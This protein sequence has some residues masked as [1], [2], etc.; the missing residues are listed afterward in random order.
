MHP[1]FTYRQL[2]AAATPGVLDQARLLAGEVTGLDWDEHSV[3]GELGRYG[4]GELMLHHAERPLTGDCPCRRRKSGLC[5]HLTAVALACLG[6]DDEL[7]QALSRLP[8][9]DLVALLCDLADRS[10]QAR[11]AIRARTTS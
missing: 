8:H 5:V 1:D 2:R 10:E 3:W 7:K 11:S 9:A 4:P 6:D